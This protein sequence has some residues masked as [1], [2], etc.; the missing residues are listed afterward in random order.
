LVS[1]AGSASDFVATAEI[2]LLIKQLRAQY[3]FELHPTNR[4]EDVKPEILMNSETPVLSR[5]IF[6][7]GRAFEES[8]DARRL[9]DLERIPACG[10]RYFIDII[11]FLP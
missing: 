9:G 5:R 8:A 4:A 6:V 11:D 2:S 3:K 1:S 10:L 7:M